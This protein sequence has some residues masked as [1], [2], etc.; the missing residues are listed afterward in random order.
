LDKI[1]TDKSVE[2]FKREIAKEIRVMVV[3]R[4]QVVHSPKVAKTLVGVAE[5]EMNKRIVDKENQLKG[6]AKK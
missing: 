2:P 5:I 6:S 1:I 4:A 3:E